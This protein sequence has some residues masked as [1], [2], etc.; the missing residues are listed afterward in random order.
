MNLGIVFH[1]G[2]IC[3]GLFSVAAMV[4]ADVD[5]QVRVV[6]F[7]HLSFLKKRSECLFGGLPIA[8]IKAHLAESLIIADILRHGRRAG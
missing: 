6:H 1:P 5:Q 7:V 3:F 8:E 2:Q 4:G